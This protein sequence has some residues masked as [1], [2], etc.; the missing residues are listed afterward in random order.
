MQG[1][2][3]LSA[4]SAEPAKIFIA[5]GDSALELSCQ[6]YQTV[7]TASAY[8]LKGHLIQ[9]SF[10]TGEIFKATVAGDAERSSCIGA[11]AVLI[12]KTQLE[13]QLPKV[14]FHV[15]P[16]DNSRQLLALERASLSHG[17]TME[18]VERAI[19]PWP[20]PVSKS[21]LSRV[22]GWASQGG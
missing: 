12:L 17:V 13:Q 5:S 2:R 9:F 19:L 8:S 21:V 1:V 14:L 4:R 11:H 18:S 10:N 16:L 20:E 3:S 15:G 7:V 22:F 6:T